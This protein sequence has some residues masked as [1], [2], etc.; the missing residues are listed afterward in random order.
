M[1]KVGSIK[2]LTPI[3]MRDISFFFIPS[4]FFKLR[5]FSDIFYLKANEENDN[6][7]EWV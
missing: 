2:H 5:L 6:M 7:V 1:W 3:Q 4:N